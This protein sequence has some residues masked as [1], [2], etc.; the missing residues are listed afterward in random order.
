MSG[1]TSSSWSTPRRVSP[2]ARC[3]EQSAHQPDVLGDKERISAGNQSSPTRT[4]TS[5]RSPGSRRGSWWIRSSGKDSRG[6]GH[7]LDVPKP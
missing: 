2:V 4:S 1:R 3:H 6:G 7:R 5:G